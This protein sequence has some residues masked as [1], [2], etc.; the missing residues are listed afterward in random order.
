VTRRQVRI[1][2]P[3]SR[4]LARPS[5]GITVIINQ[6]TA[7]VSGDGI[8]TVVNVGTIW[9]SAYRDYFQLDGSADYLAGLGGDDEFDLAGF[10]IEVDGE[11]GNDHFIQRPSAFFEGDGVYGGPGNDSLTGSAGADNL[12][13]NMDPGN[14]TV[15]GYEGDDT[16]S[17]SD[18][19]SGNDTIEAEGGTDR[20]TADVGD[21]LT[22]CEA[23]SPPN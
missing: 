2:A 5:H 6:R 7:Q 12:N 10:V 22:G 4:Q 13:L 19:V 3:P 9:G 8:D 16:L 18:G 20:C 1:Q 14:D 17:V 21:L 15:I 23:K 11:E